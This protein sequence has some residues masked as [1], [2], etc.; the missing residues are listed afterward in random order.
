MESELVD[1]HFDSA[2]WDAVGRGDPAQALEPELAVVIDLQE[3]AARIAARLAAF[4][5]EAG[6]VQTSDELR[7]AA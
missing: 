1:S 7:N 4:R 2:Y 3:R 6:F 5:A